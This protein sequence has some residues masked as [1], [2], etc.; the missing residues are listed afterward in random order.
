MQSCLFWITQGLNR[1]HLE[2]KRE[3]G[4]FYFIHAAFYII[5]LT[6][7][8]YLFILHVQSG[9]MRHL[10]HTKGYLTPLFSAVCVLNNR[11]LSIT[12]KRLN[13]FIRA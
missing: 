9:Y 13:D 4:Q 10:Q 5:C 8:V 6:L 1:N 2:G 11:I 7:F 3:F 12:Y